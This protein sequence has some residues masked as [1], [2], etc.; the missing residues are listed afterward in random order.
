M[1][2]SGYLARQFA[3]P[4][5][6]VGKHIIG[7]WLVRTNRLSN[8]AVFNQLDLQPDWQVAEIGFGGGELLSRMADMIQTGRVFGIDPSTELIARF[9][10][11]HASQTCRGRIELKQ[12]TA[13]LLPLGEQSMNLLVSVNT[14]YFWSSLETCL[15]ECVRVLKPRGYLVLG[16]SDGQLLS[17]SGYTAHGYRTWSLEDVS[18]ALASVGF[19][20][21]SV[22]T[23]PRGNRG[24]FFVLKGQAA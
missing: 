2:V 14:I 10:N 8:D 22:V 9:Q 5:G 4:S 17:D 3:R 20:V 7:P 24:D 15:G 21:V 6:W 23:L 18:G 16:F 12:G 19:S 11:R 1:K 13:E